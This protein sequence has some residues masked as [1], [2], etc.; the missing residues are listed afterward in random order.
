MRVKVLCLFIGLVS[1]QRTELEG[2]WRIEDAYIADS[3]LIADGC[4]DHVELMLADSLG[5]HMRYKPSATTLPIYR[6][7]LKRIPPAPN[8]SLRA[9][10]VIFIETGRQVE[11]LCGWGYKPKVGEIDLVEIRPR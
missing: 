6:L 5:N 2:T 8:T 11:L 9:V 1:C 10:K 4:E 7:A 3:S